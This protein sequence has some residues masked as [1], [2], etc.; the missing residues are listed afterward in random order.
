MSEFKACPFCGKTDKVEFD[1]VNGTPIWC[2]RW[3]MWDWAGAHDI[4]NWNSRPIEDALRAEIARLEQRNEYLEEI[5]HDI[6]SW[7]KAY[8]LKI[9]NEP[10]EQEWE[11]AHAVM[12]E[13]GMNL[14]QFAVSAMRRITTG[15]SEIIAGRD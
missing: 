6:D 4:T 3:G 2:D 8:P 11:I 12:K 5:Q 7:C 14:S 13:H 10:T 1:P 9:A 15:I